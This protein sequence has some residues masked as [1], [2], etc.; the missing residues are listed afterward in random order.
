MLTKTTTTTQPPGNE[1]S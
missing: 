1:K